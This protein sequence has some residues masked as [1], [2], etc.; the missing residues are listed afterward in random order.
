MPKGFQETVVTGGITFIDGKT[1]YEQFRH[2]SDGSLTDS[3]AKAS[4]REE[5]LVSNNNYGCNLE[6]ED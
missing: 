6:F 3:L 2:D 5:H 4:D 1:S